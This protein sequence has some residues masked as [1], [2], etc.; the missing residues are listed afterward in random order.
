MGC[1]E[2]K[3]FQAL[4]KTNEF[5]VWN[6]DF[7][8]LYINDHCLQKLYKIFQ[9]IDLDN[10]GMI[11]FTELLMLLDLEY[12]KFTKRIFSIFDNDNSGEID[13]YEFVLTLWNYCTLTKTTL[14]KLLSLR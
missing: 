9:D 5:K 2:S 8:K 11:G 13:F 4:K 10:S 12:T 3:Q 14:G 6:I 1:I 7:K